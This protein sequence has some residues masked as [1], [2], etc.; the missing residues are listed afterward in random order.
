MILTVGNTKGGTGKSTI[1]V[2]LAIHR[3]KTRKV[4]LVDGDEQKSAIAFTEL[5]NRNDYAAVALTSISLRQQVPSLS[6][7]YQDV[8]IDVGGRDSGSLRAAMTISDTLLIPI[9]PRTFDVWAMENM[10]LLIDEATQFNEK[11]VVFTVL[12]MADAQGKANADAKEALAEYPLNHLSEVIMRRKVYSDSIAN[13]LG[14]M[15][16]KPRNAKAITEFENV[17]SV[18]YRSPV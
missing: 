10:I 1:A 5:R 16:M 17:L 8:V 2:N 3:A 12:N 15:E 18:L 4:L 7:N 6:K 9:Q 14:M 13:G 11:L